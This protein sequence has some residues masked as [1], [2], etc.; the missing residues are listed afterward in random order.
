[1]Q[2]QG[3]GNNRESRVN[4]E[5]PRNCKSDPDTVGKHIPAHDVTVPKLRGGKAA[6]H[7]RSQ[8][9]CLWQALRG[10]AKDRKEKTDP[11][12]RFF[13]FMS[14]TVQKIALMG[15]FIALGNALGYAF[16]SIPNVELITA[17]IFIAGY[18]L[19]IKYGIVVGIITEA[20]YSLFNPFGMAAPPLLFAQVV[21]MGITGF[22]G[23][24]LGKQNSGS[25]LWHHITT[26][27]AGLFSTF[28]FAFLTTI[29]YVTF[30]GFD[31]NKIMASIVYGL[32]FYLL[33]M[34]SNTVIFFTLVPVLIRILSK[35]TKPV[36]QIP[37][38]ESQ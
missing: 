26:G 14:P 37:V 4:R 35:I 22:L 9:T 16:I 12:G 25:R 10:K 33:H 34:I 24:S 18:V 17:T 3:S 11:R 21:S 23:G 2:K 27:A 32:G 28:I 5:L 20:I 38:G 29:S 6:G 13:C 36:M 30:T 19:G 7:G 8:E 15:A 1:M 31:L